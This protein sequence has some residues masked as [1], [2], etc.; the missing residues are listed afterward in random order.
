MSGDLEDFLRRAAQRRQAKAAQ[1]QQPAERQ[2][3]QYSDSRTERIVRATE[4]EEILEAEIVEEDPD[5]FSARMRRLE[6][7]KRDRLTDEFWCITNAPDGS[8]ADESSRDVVLSG[9]PA[10]DLIKLI[11][12]PGGLQQAILMREIFDRPEH[13]W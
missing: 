10:R 9:N 12:Q 6:E 7:A 1:Q 3:P 11:R 4:P 2:R 8:P 13:R 5:S